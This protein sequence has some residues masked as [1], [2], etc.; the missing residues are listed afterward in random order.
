MKKFSNGGEESRITLL[1]VVLT[2]TTDKPTNTLTVVTFRT[3]LPVKKKQI[4]KELS[5]LKSLKIQT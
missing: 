5:F 4:Q 2:S 1:K 3:A